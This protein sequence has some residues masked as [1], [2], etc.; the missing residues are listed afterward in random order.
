[1][2]E[3]EGEAGIGY[4]SQERGMHYVSGGVRLD[5]GWQ[6]VWLWRMVA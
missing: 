4:G 6:A 3:A 2:A 5:L 1:M